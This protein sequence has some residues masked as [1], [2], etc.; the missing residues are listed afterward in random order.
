MQHTTSTARQQLFRPQT[1]RCPKCRSPIVG[2]QTIYGPEFVCDC[3]WRGHDDNQPQDYPD[4][5]ANRMDT[6]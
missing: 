3:T 4:D 6:P 2:I 5:V 1:T